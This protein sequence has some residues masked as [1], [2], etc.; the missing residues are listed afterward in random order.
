[1]KVLLV[2]PPHYYQ[3]KSRKASF[4]PLG[5]GYVAPAESWERVIELE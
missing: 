2:Q 4:F 3:S 1:M 5:L